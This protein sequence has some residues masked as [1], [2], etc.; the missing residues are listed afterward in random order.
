MDLCGGLWM[1]TQLPAKA[2]WPGEEGYKEHKEPKEEDQASGHHVHGHPV[3]S[4]EESWLSL[5]TWFGTK[6]GVGEAPPA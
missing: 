5:G 4:A 3:G 6:A 2:S 1:V